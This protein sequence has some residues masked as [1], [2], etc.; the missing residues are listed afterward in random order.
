MGQVVPSIKLRST[1]QGLPGGPSEVVVIRKLEQRR[2]QLEEQCAEL[3]TKCVARP[4]PPAYATL[5]VQTPLPPCV[6]KY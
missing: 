1:L 3:S 4:E 5:Q 2:S 6:P